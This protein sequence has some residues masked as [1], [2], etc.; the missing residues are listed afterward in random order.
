[1]RGI[2]Y[3]LFPWKAW[4]FQRNMM[5]VERYAEGQW[6]ATD[7]SKR[8]WKEME[9]SGEGLLCQRLDTSWNGENKSYSPRY[10]GFFCNLRVRKPF[11]HIQVYFSLNHMYGTQS[12][13]L[14]CCSYN[15]PLSTHVKNLFIQILLLKILTFHLSTIILRGSEF[16][17]LLKLMTICHLNPDTGW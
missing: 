17:D 4:Q 6:F 9:I 11:K 2:K 8:K 16:L 14:I 13:N 10:S 15:K 3:S 1:M 12:K 7:E 5:I